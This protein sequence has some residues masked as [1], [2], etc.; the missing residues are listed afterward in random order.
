MA[1]LKVEHLAYAVTVDG[2]R[3]VL[4]DAS[5]VVHGGLITH[6]DKAD[7][8]ADISADKVIDGSRLLAMPGMINGH[9][10]ISYAHA[11]RGIF[12]DDVK[13]RLAQVFLMQNA[14]TAEEEHVVTLLGLVEMLTTGTTTFVD[15]GTTRFPDAVLDAYR[16]AGCRVMTGEHVTDRDNPVN[17]P[18]YETGEAIARLEAS[19]ATLDGR[20]DG[21]MSAWTMPFSMQ[22]CSPE[23]LQ[24]AKRIA[25]ENHTMMTLHHGGGLGKDGSAPTRVLA[26]LNVLGPNVMLSHCMGLTEEEIAIVAD[27]GATVVMCPSTV[28]KSAGGIADNGRLPELLA[29]GVP[30]AL[31]TDSVNSSNFTDLVR[32]MQLASTVYKDARSDTSLVS[33]ETSVELATRT[34]ALAVGRPDLGA[35]EVGRRADIVLFDTS[36]PH[37]RGLTDPVRNLVHSATGDSVHTVLVD[38]KV[39]VENGRPTFVDDLWGLIEQVEAAGVRIRSSTGVKHPSGWPVT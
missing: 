4:A 7:R 36:K 28:V 29:A 11:V 33:P 15:P 35:L 34:G 2:D 13:D 19:I 6:V 12:P 38:G 31:G 8:L 16:V 32:S 22:Y 9:L 39:T 14:M 30:V 37:W 27:T 23:L 25:D 17:L 5:V 18:V 24:A 20:L 3:R 26:D 10:H 21:R 1:D